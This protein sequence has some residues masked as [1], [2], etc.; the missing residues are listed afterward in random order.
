MSAATG[1]GGNTLPL[2][3]ERRVNE[4]CNRFE[5]AWQAGGRPRVEDYLGDAAGAERGALLRELVLLEVAYRRRRDEA[6]GR[7]DYLARFPGLPADWVAGAVAEPA[8]ARVGPYRLLEPVGRGGMGEVYKGH[9]PRLGRDLAV[10]VLRDRHRGQPEYVRRFVEEARITGRLQHPGIPPVHELGQLPDGSPFLA[11]KLFRGQTLAAELAT[12]AAQLAACE[13]PDAP[14]VQVLE[15]KDLWALRNSQRDSLEEELRRLTRIFEQVCQAVAYAHS[16]GVIHRDLKP[17]NIMVAAFGE[18]QVMDWGLAKRL[19]EPATA[20]TGQGAAPLGLETTPSD[21]GACGEA[22]LTRPGAVMGTFAYMSPEQARG[23]TELVDARADVFALGAI[24]CQILTGQPPYLGRTARELWEQAAAGELTATMA[25]LNQHVKLHV[26]SPDQLEAR[27]ASL[28]IRCLAPVP[29]ERPAHA[30]EV[31]VAVTAALTRAAEAHRQEELNQLRTDVEMGYGKRSW[32]T[33]GLRAMGMV[34]LLVLIWFLGY[35]YR[36]GTVQEAK[37]T[38]EKEKELQWL[39]KTTEE[40]N[41]E[42]QL[43]IEA[44][45]KGRKP[46]LESSKKR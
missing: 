43:R 34:L 24:L 44:E 23:E 11:M 5:L 19:R 10:K 1:T 38:A 45:N 39:Q 4:A 13:L 9:D 21:G 14:S 22:D 35:A 36:A 33:P 26:S 17:A 25:R 3:A 40:A 37:W 32:F 27:L 7:D 41:K 46:W 28:A 16:Q 20:T 29:S 12:R 42:K 30:G 18:T 15:L 31:A 8:P 2:E 6:P